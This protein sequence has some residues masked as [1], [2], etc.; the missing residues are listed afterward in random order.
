MVKCDLERIKHT[1]D[2]TMIEMK[3][4]DSSLK[5]IME[6][7]IDTQNNKKVLNRAMSIYM[8]PDTIDVEPNFIVM[9]AGNQVKIFRR[10]VNYFLTKDSS[11]LLN[12][13][14]GDFGEMM[15]VLETGQYSAEVFSINKSKTVSLKTLYYKPKSLKISGDKNKSDFGITEFDFQMWATNCVAVNDTSLP[16][17]FSTKPSGDPNPRNWTGCIKNYTLNLE[18]YGDKT[19]SESKAWVGGLVVALLFSFGVM[20]AIV[21]YFYRQSKRKQRALQEKIEIFS[22]PGFMEFKEGQEVFSPAHSRNPSLIE[23]AIPK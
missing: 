14:T 4:A 15:Q 6:Y 3:P 19:F 2:D 11:L 7:V 20:I 8:V 16:F 1:R 17:I 22:S 5:D 9:K 21:C 23:N 13:V 18:F 10:Y 12:T